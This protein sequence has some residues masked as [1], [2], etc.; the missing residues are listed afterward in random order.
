MFEE[1]EN[2]KYNV[3]RSPP[4]D[5]SNFILVEKRKIEEFKC[6]ECDGKMFCLIYYRS[7][8]RKIIKQYK[9]SKCNLETWR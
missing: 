1:F 3:I 4:V 7:S 9:C 2:K 8:P 5:I 6:G